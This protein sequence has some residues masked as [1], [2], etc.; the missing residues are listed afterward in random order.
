MKTPETPFKTLR[1]SPVARAV[2]AAAFVAAPVASLAACSAASLGHP[3]TVSSPAKATFE[4]FA[5][6]SQPD[7]MGQRQQALLSDLKKKGV[8]R[9]DVSAVTVGQDAALGT[10][11]VEAYRSKDSRY[12]EGW[13]ALDSGFSSQ[14][15]AE[16][17]VKAVT[18][19]LAHGELVPFGHQLGVCDLPVEVT[20][21]PTPTR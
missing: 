11:N 6:S 17:C 16:V 8:A 10:W 5:R 12:G 15:A 3:E 7:T 20:P 9:R 18:V 4:A 21:A 13:M 2:L 1:R 19:A 14:R